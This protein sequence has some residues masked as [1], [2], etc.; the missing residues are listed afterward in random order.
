MCE[1][2]HLPRISGDL[3]AGKMGI[4]E[5]TLTNIGQMNWLTVF[6]LVAVSLMLLF[7]ALEERSP[8]F[9]AGF[10]G[11]CLLASLYGFLQGAW[12]FGLVEAIWFV[13]AIRRWHKLQIRLRPAPQAPINNVRDFLAGL[14]TIAK[15]VG[16]GDF[17]FPS[18]DGSPEGYVQLIVDSPQAVTIHRVWSLQSGQGTG[19]KILRALCE[20]ADRHGVELA[21][22][23]IPIGRQP[24]PMTRDQLVAWYQRHG[25][26]GTR[27]KMV[28]RPQAVNAIQSD[29]IGARNSA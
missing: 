15:P 3:F 2:N 26:E 8:L 24:H 13:V 22:K 5:K 4:F 1:G 17:S 28:R 14:E 27:R 11:A 19:S 12:P 9:V 21:L 29:L 25:F 20:L 18:A 16:R 23:V 10:A 6:G 7:Y